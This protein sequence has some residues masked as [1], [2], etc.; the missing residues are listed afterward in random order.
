MNTSGFCTKT[1]PRSGN[2]DSGHSSTAPNPFTGLLVQSS[3][4]PSSPVSPWQKNTSANPAITWLI[5]STSTISANS[6]DT[7]AAAT[8]ARNREMPGVP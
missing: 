2:S 3:S 1:L 7:T 5:R 4:V 8:M 6:N